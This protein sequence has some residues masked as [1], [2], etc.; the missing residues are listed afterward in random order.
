MKRSLPVHQYFQSEMYKCFPELFLCENHWKVDQIVISIYP[1]WYRNNGVRGIE[2]K[3]GDS[4]D[5]KHD[6]VN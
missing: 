6:T 4:D 5:S 1:G 3:K 2:L